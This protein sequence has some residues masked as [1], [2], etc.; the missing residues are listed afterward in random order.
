[1]VGHELGPEG[2]LLQVL[3]D[4]IEQGSSQE[5]DQYVNRNED[6]SVADVHELKHLEEHWF[7]WHKPH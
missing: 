6:H 5:G 2:L 3:D 4:Q 7:R 1:M